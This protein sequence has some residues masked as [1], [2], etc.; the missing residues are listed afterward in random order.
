MI[1]SN[2]EHFHE[3]LGAISH[4][5]MEEKAARE[6]LLVLATKHCPKKH[7]DWEEICAIARMF[8]EA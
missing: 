8:G 6:R 2:N 1:A 3:F 5:Y 4:L 7:H